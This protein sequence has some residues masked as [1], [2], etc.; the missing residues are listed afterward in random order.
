M[1]KMTKAK[2]SAA[3]KK[4][5]KTRKANNQR[6]QAKRK[7]DAKKAKAAGTD[8]EI[9]FKKKLVRNRHLVLNGKGIPDIIAKKAKK[10]TFY[11]IKP[12]QMRRGY[13]SKGSWKTVGDKSRLL[14]SNQY[15]E[16]K[17]L[18]QRGVDVYMVYYYRKTRGTKTN[19]RYKFKYNEIKLT[20]KD[21]KNRIGPD[22]EKFEIP[23]DIQR[24]KAVRTF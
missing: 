2:R 14:R 12:H 10:W 1:A 16:F 11:E 15:K 21:F 8:S 5:A 19:P 24:W 17:K 18:V 22:P 13:N 20:R 7:K 6:S 4:A 9:G 3:A 23:E